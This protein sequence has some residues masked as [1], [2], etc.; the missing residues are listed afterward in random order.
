M[1]RILKISII[2][3]LI[4]PFFSCEAFFTYSWF[5]GAADI[6]N[7]SAE[8]AINSGDIS[9]MEEVFDRIMEDAA[10]ASGS[11]AAGLYLDAADLALGISGMSDPTVL[12]SATESL[13]GGGTDSLFAILTDTGV[14]LATLANVDDILEAANAADPASVPADIWLFAAAGSAAGIAAA[15]ETAGQDVGDF[16]PADPLTDP[17]LFKVYNIWFML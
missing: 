11:E 1:I 16:L 3:L 17:T 6:S 2:I 15:A 9:I 5:Q 8:E 13:D 4:L 10:S 14:D 12:L 7:I